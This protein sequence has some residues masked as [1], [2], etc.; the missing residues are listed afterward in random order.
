MRFKKYIKCY[1]NCATSQKKK[2]IIL[3]EIKFVLYAVLKHDTIH[4]K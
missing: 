1:C 2:E 3:H 4:S